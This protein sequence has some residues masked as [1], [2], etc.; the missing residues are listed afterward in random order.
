[1]MTIS[2]IAKTPQQKSSKFEINGREVIQP[3]TWYTC[4]A[5]KVAKVKG[6]V[7]CTLTGAGAQ[8][9]FSVA[10]TIMYRWV[11]AYPAGWNNNPLQRNVNELIGSG[12]SSFPK[13]QT[14]QDF[15]VTLSAGQT[16]VTSQDSGT[17]AEFNVF[18][19]VEEFL[20]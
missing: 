16:I 14:F 15:D 7:V 11:P 17:N 18:A 1:M 3:F 9:R 20:V 19:E 13:V 10:G 4:P 12:A 6:S 2:I 5:G 8:A